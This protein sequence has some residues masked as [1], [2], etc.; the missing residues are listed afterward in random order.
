[1]TLE[2]LAGCLLT[3]LNQESACLSFDDAELLKAYLMRLSDFSVTKMDLARLKIGKTVNKIYKKFK[4]D[5]AFKLVQ[6][7]KNNIVS[8]KD[9]Q[10]K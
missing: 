5:E 2:A 6:K 7:W 3:F 9:S 10:M 1:V 8:K 4:V